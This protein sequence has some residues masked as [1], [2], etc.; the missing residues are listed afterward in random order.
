MNN[1]RALDA[2]RAEVARHR[3]KR[4]RFLAELVRV[5]SDN[6]PGDC[7][8]IA[9]RAAELLEELGLTVE[10]YPVPEEVCRA[11]GMIA[12]TNL[13]VRRS[14]GDGPVVALNAHGD[15]VAPGDGWTHDPYGAEVVDGVMYGRGVAV[16]KSDFATY[17]FAL[18]AL[19]ALPESPAGTVELHFTFDEE[20]GGEIGPGRL[21]AEGISRP[22]W[23]INAGFAYSVVTAHN[24]CLHLEVTVRGRSAHA[25]MPESGHDAL[26]AAAGVLAA[27][28]EESDHLKAIHSKVPGIDTAS[29]NIG[30]IEGGINTTVVP[31]RVT[32]RVDRRIIP[33]EDPVKVEQELRALVTRTAVD[34]PG[35]SCDIERIMLAVPLT[36][37]P[38]TE[39]LA[40]VLARNAEQV[41]GEAIAKCG[42]PLFTDARHYSE[43]GIPT[44]IYGAG[45]RTLLEAGGHGPDE[46]L[47]LEDLHAATLVVSMALYE[48][49]A[50]ERS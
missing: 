35:I 20:V 46:R 11:N 16:S 10:R 45:P 37:V 6:P 44:V 39:K 49:L 2:L 36:H 9:E 5:P 31:D 50:P 3:D 1:E 33:D 47:R 48:L 18:L 17:A 43:A 14:F 40:E 30:L 13:V 42:V 21:L 12:A 23:C 22:D 32:F 8:P 34:R 24:G 19:E 25:A 28:Y 38:G 27:L 29:L 26:A 15:V 4:E 41:L 7:R